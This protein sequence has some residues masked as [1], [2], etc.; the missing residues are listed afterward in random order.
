MF[1]FFLGDTI[2]PNERRFREEVRKL[3]QQ[4]PDKFQN[5]DG[6]LSL[7]SAGNALHKS[8]DAET[9]GAEEKGSRCNLLKRIEEGN[10]IKV[11][12]NGSSATEAG[13]RKGSKPTQSSKDECS[14]KALSMKS[15]KVIM[16]QLKDKDNALTLRLG[17][18]QAQ[19][20]DNLFNV[21]L[22]KSAGKENNS[23]S[24]SWNCYPYNVTPSV[25]K[26]SVGVQ[27]SL[28][29]GVS[30]L[31]P[32]ASA[33]PSNKRKRSTEDSD[34]ETSL[35]GGK[36]DNVKCISTCIP[37]GSMMSVKIP[38]YTATSAVNTTLSKCN[39]RQGSSCFLLEFKSPK[40]QTARHFGESLPLAA[41]SKVVPA[42]DKANDVTPVTSPLQAS[43]L[44]S[45]PKAATKDNIIQMVPIAPMP[46]DMSA[47]KEN[48]EPINQP[49]CLGS[50]PASGSTATRFFLPLQVLNG[51][52][53]RSSP[54][55]LLPKIR[56]DPFTEET[57][58][59]L[60]LRESNQ[61]KVQR[62][63]QTLPKE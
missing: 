24:Q 5:V 54:P 62:M 15:F 48:C 51:E 28:L 61:S 35:D 53:Q 36:S 52:A 58:T 17:I 47:D 42:K 39:V 8:G 57:P 7:L 2:S 49:V 25:Q 37:N 38:I 44:E 10:V 12:D 56:R 60:E 40:T 9:A 29:D 34:R 41:N 33:S 59:R 50:T 32:F 16:D 22:F 6:L 43:H 21:P 18:E 1:Y 45:V 19:T 55:A 26:A 4:F 13:C 3:Q 31:K 30:P 27:A 11:S 20:I 46:F 23:G 63:L 14:N